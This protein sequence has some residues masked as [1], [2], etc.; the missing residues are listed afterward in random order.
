MVILKNQNGTCYT[1]DGAYARRQADPTVIAKLSGPIS[2]GGG[3]VPVV[4]GLTDNE[5]ITAFIVV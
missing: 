5:I 1:T 4:T 2:Q 3:G